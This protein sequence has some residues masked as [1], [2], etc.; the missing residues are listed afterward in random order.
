MT[1]LELGLRLYSMENIFINEDDL[2]ASEKEEPR[3]LHILLKDKDCLIESVA[4]GIKPDL[5]D[6]FGNVVPGHFFIDKNKFLF[7]MIYD[8]FNKYQTLLTRGAM[9][10]IIDKYPSGSDEQKAA[11]KGHWDK[12]W[13]RHDVSTQDYGLLRDR[14]NDRYVGMQGNKLLAE[15]QSRLKSTEYKTDVVKDI[16]LKMDS[17]DNLEPDSYS[18]TMGIEEG[19]KDAMQYVNHRRENPDDFGGIFTG[20]QSLDKVVYGLERGSYTVVSG[21]IN[22]GKTTLLFNIGFNMAKAGN[23]VAYASLEKEAKPFFRRILSLHASTDYNRIKRGGKEKNGLSDYWYGKLKEAADDLI[24]NIKPHYDCLQFLPDTTLTKILSDVDKIR[25]TKRVDVLIVDYLQVIKTETSHQGRSDLDLADIH[26][27]LKAYGRKHNIVIITAMQLKKDSSK[28]MRKKIDKVNSDDD[29]S[30]LEVNTE[31]I[32]GSQLVTADAE[33]AFIVFLNKDKPP[34]KMTLTIAKARDDESKMTVVLD[35]DGRVGRVSDQEYGDGQVRA[36][37]DIVYN[38][39]ITEEQLASE[40]DLFNSV[41][42]KQKETSLPETEKQGADP[43]NSELDFSIEAHSPSP[44]SPLSSS[45]SSQEESDVEEEPKAEEKGLGIAEAIVDDTD[46][47][48]GAFMKSIGK[49]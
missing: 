9:D 40:D 27:R 24:N 42:E 32:S 6:K 29:A 37:D 36:V 28:E 44:P 22:G 34:T 8:N 16:K 14:I 30:R 17:I 43:N 12:V 46:D 47:E 13:N 18:L 20:I 15:L 11:M 10:I 21:A 4:F 5:T 33:N 39:D 35:F 31:D 49:Q 48:Y 26:R 7:K 2:H 3:F 38:N 23:N 45:S 25:A 19:I 1:F 41:E